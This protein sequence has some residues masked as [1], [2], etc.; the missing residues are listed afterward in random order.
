LSNEIDDKDGESPPPG[1]KKAEADDCRPGVESF[2]RKHHKSLVGFL[3]GML[4]SRAEAEEVAQEAYVRVLKRGNRRS[5][6]Y[7]RHFLFRTA[8]NLAID[9]LRQQKYKDRYMALSRHQGEASANS[10]GN[11]AMASDSLHRVREFLWELPEAYRAA[12]LMYR[13][14]NI[15]R[16]EVARRLSVTTRT[17]NRRV[18]VALA[19]C[20]LRLEGHPEDKA[21]ELVRNE[22]NHARQ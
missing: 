16:D 1:R 11:Q 18:S 2:Y 21:R 10:G 20:A 3:E 13:F 15:P 9:R 4:S 14:E 5:E 22:R 12:T 8:K 6:A 19:Y 17:V 7:L